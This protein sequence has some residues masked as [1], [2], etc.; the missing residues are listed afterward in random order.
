MMLTWHPN[1]W[2]IAMPA[3]VPL[4]HDVLDRITSVVPYLRKTARTRLALLVTGILLAQSCVEARVAE[5]LLV[6]ELTHAT[7]AES[8]ARRL[9]RIFNDDRL[10]PQTC[11]EPALAH[12]VDWQ[13]VLATN[14]P[15]LL[16]LDESA[17]T[18]IIHLVRISLAYRGSSV[19]LVWAVWEQNVAQP[20]GFYWQ[21]LDAL[22]ERAAA[23]I[24]AGAPV[25][26]LADRGYE[27]PAVID[28]LTARGWHW[29]I[30]LR[31]KASTRVLDQ[32]GREHALTTVF[33]RRL[34]HRGQRC[35]FRGK[36]FKDAGWRTVS[37][38]AL[39]AEREDAALAIITDFPPSYSVLP[40]YRKR[41]WIECGFRTDKS[42]GWQWEACQVRDLTHHRVLLL[43]MAWASV[44]TLCLGAEEAEAT[45][46]KQQHH[47]P[48]RPEHARF[49]LFSLGLKRLR[50]FLHHP[51]TWHLRWLLPDL[52]APSWNQQWLTLQRRQYLGQTV[53]P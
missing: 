6:L 33:G 30:R 52:N 27:A 43:A 32:Q 44:I 39:W 15:V 18:D 46:A 23:L 13:A 28:R 48:R 5:E 41:F 36:L 35:K 50:A 14:Q 40:I 37:V 25:T 20:A 11:Y 3:H 8:I 10:D 17:D 22:L 24:P 2:S 34:Q 47:P 21:T 45:L 19:P 42:A 49:S 51:H 12:L 7:M 38:V 9:R 16:L 29:V 31:T 1:Q 26:V 4:F 53:R